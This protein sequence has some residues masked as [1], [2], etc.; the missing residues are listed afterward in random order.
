MR[1]CGGELEYVEILA[2]ALFAKFV[3]VLRTNLDG[4]KIIRTLL[5]NRRGKKEEEF[6]NITNFKV[7]D[8]NSRVFF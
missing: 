7:A 6:H 8:N 2:L 3:L 5:L 1:F 4:R